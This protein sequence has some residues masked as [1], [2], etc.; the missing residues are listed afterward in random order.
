MGLAALQATRAATG[1][2][3]G[4]AAA[5]SRVAKAERIVT[6][7]DTMKEFGKRLIVFHIFH[8]STYRGSWGGVEAYRT[9][10]VTSLITG[11]ITLV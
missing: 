8:R 7:L 5:R 10:P 4:S 11:L 1:V 2:A 9:G 3:I 6:A